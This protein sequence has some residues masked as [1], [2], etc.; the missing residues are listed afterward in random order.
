MVAKESGAETVIGRGRTRAGRSFVA[1]VVGKHH[2][3]RSLFPGE[4]TPTSNC[5]LSVAITEGRNG[6]SHVECYSRMETPVRPGV[7]C[8]GGQWIIHMQTSDDARRVR[9]TLNDGRSASSPLMMVPRRLGGPARLY[10]QA[11][12]ATG[13]SPVLLTELAGDGNELRRVAVPTGAGC[14][15]TTVQRLAGS[16]IQLARFVLADGGVATIATEDA[17]I[18]GTVSYGL[19]LVVSGAEPKVL[20]SASL[21]IA[22]P[23]QG[24]HASSRVQLRRLAALEWEVARACSSGGETIVYGVAA[25]GNMVSVWSGNRRMRVHNVVIAPGVRPQGVLFYTITTST[26]SRL[27]MSASSGR[28]AVDESIGKAVRQAACS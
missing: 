16:G 6:V 4:A 17:R 10:Y 2:E 11:I 18:T 5:P 13:S 25:P 14:E 19:R 8:L 15:K 3:K 24:L 27:T 1:T 7:E 12:S 9:L 23:A 28:T 20:R 22:Q 26:P 21:R